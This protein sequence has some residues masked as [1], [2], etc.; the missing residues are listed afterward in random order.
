MN[1][2]VRETSNHILDEGDVLLADVAARV[3]LAPS[4]YATAGERYHTLA[5]WVDREGSLLH[6][7]VGLVYGQGGV[8]TGSVVAN[9]ASNDEYD[10]D[11]IVGLLVAPTS[12]PQLVLDALFHSVRGERGSRYYDVTE[13]CTRCVQVSYADGM[14]VDLTPAVLLTGRRDRESIIFHHRP[15]T[16]QI[17]GRHVLAN[18]YGFAEW[19]KANTPAESLF[20]SAFS[21]YQ[22]MARALAKAQTE[23][24]PEQVKPHETSRALLSLQLTKRFRNLRYN[25]REVRCPPSVVLSKLIAEHKVH[26]TGFGVALL[27]HVTYIR[28]EFRSAHEAGWLFHAANPV[29]PSDVLTD[30]WPGTLADQAM[31]CRDLDHYVAQLTLYVLGTPTLAQRQA[32]LGDLFGEQ[33]ARSAVLDFAQRMGGD[34][35]AGRSRY[36]PGS[37]RL[38]VPAAPAIL[39][40]TR[41]RTEPQTSYYGGAAWWRP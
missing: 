15:E 4:N 23:P 8:A 31:W 19:F 25:D 32:I 21:S 36:V 5:D 2:I 34:K 12:D 30:R 18:P 16:P 1:A 9:R 38:I 6:G 20:G 11:A 37:G 26:R 27:S 7:K 33:A 41:G 14:H 17:P 13:R 3:Q 39:T 29:C 35:E 10:V 22:A 40:P 24:L 28:D